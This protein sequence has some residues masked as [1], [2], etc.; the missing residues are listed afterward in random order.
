[1]Q[2]LASG[3]A[4]SSQFLKYFVYDDPSFDFLKAD[5]GPKY[6]RDRQKTALVLDA[7]N[8]DLTPFRK[9]GGKLIQYHGWNDPAIPPLGSPRYAGELRQAMGD[10]SDFYR[11]YMVPG[12]LHCRGG[13]G[14]GEV[15][16]LGVLDRW[17]SE[18]AAPRADW[19]FVA[20]PW[21]GGALVQLVQLHEEKRP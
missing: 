21:L 2:E 4:I 19:L 11:L 8:P 14:P 1:M 15:D 10:T 6:D 7:V 16:W 3:Y 12:M 9:R 5:L 13:A 20:D 17:V 18:G